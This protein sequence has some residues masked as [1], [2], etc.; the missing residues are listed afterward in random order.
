MA[1]QGTSRKRMP[2]DVL[3]ARERARIRMEQLIVEAAANDH[4]PTYR[5]MRAVYLD[6]VL[7]QPTYIDRNHV[8]KHAE[9]EWPQV[10]NEAMLP[11]N[12]VARE[13]YAAFMESIGGT[14]ANVIT[15]ADRPALKVLHQADIDRTPAGRR[16]AARR[17]QD[18]RPPSG[19]RRGRNLRP[20]HRRGAGPP[21]G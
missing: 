19:R 3:E 10:P 13:I 21:V 1:D 5:L 15:G 4:I 16:P 14:T 18:P 17:P 20:R 11:I 12:Q 8:Q 9:I 2:P 7:V 6:E